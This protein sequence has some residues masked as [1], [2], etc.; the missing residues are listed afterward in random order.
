M[1]YSYTQVSGG[2]RWNMMRR[3]LLEVGIEPISIA[4][5]DGQTHLT[6]SRELTT[7]EV[8]NL[9][10]LMAD[11]PTFP[12]STGVRVLIRDLW[13]EWDAFK[14]ACGLPDLQIFYHESTT[15]SG[16]V[17]RIQLWHP[18]P[19]STA[20]KNAVQTAYRNLWIG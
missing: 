14:V 6:F 1:T 20:Q 10:T 8:A 15:G 3:C 4:D 18:T 12:P 5:S 19:L 13:E 11:N 17:D 2:Y 16:K 7:E 9:T